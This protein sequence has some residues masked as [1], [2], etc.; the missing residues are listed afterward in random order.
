MMKVLRSLLLKICSISFIPLGC[1]LAG[2]R[3]REFGSAA[4]QSDLMGNSFAL[5]SNQVM[6][7]TYCPV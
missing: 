6:Q 7:S 3:S 4:G 2:D 1:S 5:F